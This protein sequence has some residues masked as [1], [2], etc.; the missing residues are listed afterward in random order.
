MTNTKNCVICEDK[1]V[2]EES[3]EGLCDDCKDKLDSF[4]LNDNPYNEEIY[5]EQL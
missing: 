5:Y 2:S 4:L 1:P 3:T